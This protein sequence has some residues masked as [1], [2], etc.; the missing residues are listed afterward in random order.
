MRTVRTAEKRLYEHILAFPQ[1]AE[2]LEHIYKIEGAKAARRY[3]YRMLHLKVRA[4]EIRNVIFLE[5]DPGGALRHE[6]NLQAWQEAGY[7]MSRVWLLN[8]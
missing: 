2:K 4:K 1:F 8:R 6:A 5:R 7:A 3:V